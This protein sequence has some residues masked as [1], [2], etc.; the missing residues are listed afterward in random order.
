MNAFTPPQTW[1]LPM[2][3]A[4]YTPSQLG[5]TSGNDMSSGARKRRLVGQA[6]SN[7]DQ[8]APN[9]I[10]SGGNA[11][12]S[13]HTSTSRTFQPL[14]KP[15]YFKSRWIESRTEIEQTWL[16]EKRDPREKL[17]T[18]LPMCGFLIGLCIAGFLIWEGYHSVSRNLY[19]P[20]MVDDFSSGRL[21]ETMWSTE[22]EVG[23]HGS[24]L[25]ARQIRAL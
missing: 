19:C 22:I 1:Q 25:F 15:G 14:D 20:V 6:N 11:N 4:Q 21:N 9:P 16:Y 8:D 12:G 18:I 13:T 23:G 24:V 3:N 10:G 5:D 2:S 17:Q 7:T